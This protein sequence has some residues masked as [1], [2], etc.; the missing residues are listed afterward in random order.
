MTTRLVLVVSRGSLIVADALVIAVTWRKLFLQAAHR[1]VG[2]IRR[3]LTLT[4]IVLRD[5]KYLVS[6]GIWKTT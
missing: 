5:G 1:E 2:L 3:R 4:D 6:F